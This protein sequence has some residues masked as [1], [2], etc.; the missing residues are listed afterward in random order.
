M[1]VSW[2]DLEPGA[3]CRMELL[4]QHWT[5]IYALSR[6]KYASILLQPL[7]FKALVTSIA[8]NTYN[9]GGQ[10]SPTLGPTAPGKR[11]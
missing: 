1:V 8:P 3:F 7:L 11:K 5:L 2:K 4:Y 6:E 9:R 10:P